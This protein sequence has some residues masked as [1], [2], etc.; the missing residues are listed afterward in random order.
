M[1]MKQKNASAGGRFLSLFF[2]IIR[3]ILNFSAGT[4]KK[5]PDVSRHSGRWFL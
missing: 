4:H 5:F 3:T 1:P 2:V